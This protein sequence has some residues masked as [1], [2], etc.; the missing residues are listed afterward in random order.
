MGSGVGFGLGV[1][2]GAATSI[3]GAWKACDAVGWELLEVLVAV[4]TDELLRS[5]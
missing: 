3:A 5:G 4:A 1:G 2:F